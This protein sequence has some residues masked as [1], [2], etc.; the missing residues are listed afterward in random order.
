MKLLISAY[1]CAPDHGS[2]HAV[3]WNWATEAHRLGYQVCVLASSVHRAAIE[4][5][6]S[7]DPDLR[8]I[9]WVFPEVRSWPLKPGVEP[10]WERTYNLLWQKAALHHARELHQRTKF[11]AVHH[12]TWG[13]VRAPTFLGSLGVPLIVGPLGG[14]ETSPL[15]LRG[16]FGLKA[17]VTE[18]IRDLSNATVTIN[19][20]VRRGLARAA[21]IFVKTPETQQLLTH[22]MRKKSIT[23][24]ELGLHD[25]AIGRPR[26]TQPLKSSPRLLYAG[27][28]LYWKG[29][30]IAIQAFAELA[31]WMPDARLTIVGRGPEEQRLRADVR[32]HGLEA[33]ID[34]IPWLPQRQ[35]FDLYVAHDLLIFPSLHDSSG[36]V[37]LEA[38]SQ[39]LPVICLDLGGPRYIV[40]DESGIVVSTVGRNTS[41]VAAAMAG[42]MLQLFASPTRLSSLSAG[43]TARAKQFILTNRVAELYHSAADFISLPTGAIGQEATLI[44]EL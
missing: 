5:A 42:E 29:V 11:D 13:G 30:H 31:R 43:A 23:R 39:G 8:G 24:M 28:L 18:K 17:K 40:T 20:M 41:Q 7:A 3:G 2:E 19:P 4:A 37:V 26:N 38:L 32:T 25:A 22:E 35:L 1:A 16:A 34:F 15:A 36:N 21:V 33:K 9:R 10:R 12:L 44:P 27:R 14:G 6:C